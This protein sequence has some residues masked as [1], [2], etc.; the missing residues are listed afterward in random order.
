MGTGRPKEFHRWRPCDQSGVHG[1][2]EHAVARVVLNCI[3][4]ASGR[5]CTLSF[6][7]PLPWLLEPYLPWGHPGNSQGYGVLWLQRSCGL[8][9]GPSGTR[10]G[11]RHSPFRYY[12]ISRGPVGGRGAYKL[13]VSSLI[14]WEHLACQPLLQEST[15]NTS[16]WGQATEKWCRVRK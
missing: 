6:P 2:G 7:V 15:P 13:R 5:R 12:G 3:S 8:G 11:T 16:P 1:L 9:P 14:M 4:E 10:M